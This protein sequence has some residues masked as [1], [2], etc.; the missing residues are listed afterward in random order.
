MSCHLKAYSL[1]CRISVANLKHSKNNINHYM[2]K[3]CT[4]YIGCN[5]LNE[6]QHQG[7]A[8]ELWLQLRVHVLL[9]AMPHRTRTKNPIQPGCIIKA[10]F[11]SASFFC[12]KIYKPAAGVQND[13]VAHG[14]TLLFPYVSPK[15]RL[16]SGEAE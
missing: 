2:A 7:I 9:I 5:H 15:K 4:R 10:V 8:P 12:V 3:S 6:V 16:P 1:N 14:A 11:S 13:F